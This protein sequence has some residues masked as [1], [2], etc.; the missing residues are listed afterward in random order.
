MLG[1]QNDKFL[2]PE[3][4]SRISELTLIA[5]HPTTR[6]T[7]FALSGRSVIVE[8]VCVDFWLVD[9]LRETVEVVAW[10]VAVVGRGRSLGSET[11]LEP[12]LAQLMRRPGDSSNSPLG[13]AGDEGRDGVGGACIGSSWI[14]RHTR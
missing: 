10:L 3:A 13:K 5:D 12:V 4:Q 9:K 11:F 14:S 7:F 2:V 1:T 6:L 8:V